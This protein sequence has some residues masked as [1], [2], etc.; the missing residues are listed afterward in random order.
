MVH[1]GSGF[2]ASSHKSVIGKGNHVEVEFCLI[3]KMSM[4]ERKRTSA[5]RCVFM[6]LH[7]NGSLGIIIKCVTASQK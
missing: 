3:Y 1:K 5:A 6:T 7:M 2:Q 4:L